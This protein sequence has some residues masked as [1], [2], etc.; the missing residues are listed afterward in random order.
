MSADT[1]APAVHATY[2]SLS[3][4]LTVM[5]CERRLFLGAVCAGA[6]AFS[7]FNAPLAG[8]VLFGAGFGL[9]LLTTRHDPALPVV[10]LRSARCRRRYDPAMRDGGP[11]PLL[12]LPEAPR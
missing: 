4:P 5:G 12:V 3:R 9:G 6:A 7:S 1:V 8:F 2:L 11:S 10:L